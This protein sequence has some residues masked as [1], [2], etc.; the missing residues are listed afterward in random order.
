MMRLQY[1][2]REMIFPT[3]TMHQQK[4]VSKRNSYVQMIYVYRWQRPRLQRHVKDYIQG[5]VNINNT[6]A[7]LNSNENFHP[8]REY[9]DWDRLGEGRTRQ[10]NSMF[11]AHPPLLPLLALETQCCLL[12]KMHSFQPS[13][14]IG[15][16]AGQ[17]PTNIFKESAL[18]HA[19]C[20]FRWTHHSL[21]NICQTTVT[22]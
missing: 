3:Q 5:G 4:S 13:V 19:R 21:K 22:T 8:S 14:G 18:I 6:N 20:A 9:M 7:L 10:H 11:S 1:K 2:N 12:P 15:Q 16:S 17:T